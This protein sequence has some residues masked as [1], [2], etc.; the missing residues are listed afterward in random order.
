MMRVIGIGKFLIKYITAK[1]AVLTVIDCT[2]AAMGVGLQ[3]DP[4]T[5]CVNPCEFTK[6]SCRSHWA[7]T[8]VVF[9]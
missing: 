4:I 2:G 9:L 8:A 5:Q 6:T 3:L 1:S 7:R